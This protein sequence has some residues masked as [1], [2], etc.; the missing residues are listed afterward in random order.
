MKC[1]I[2]GDLDPRLIILLPLHQS[3]GKLDT[4]ACEA[5]ATK[6]TV[7]CV[8]H[9]RPHQGFRDGTTAC[10][11]CVEELVKENISRVF[12]I[13][14]EVLENLSDEERNRLTDAIDIPSEIMNCSSWDTILRFVACKA[15]RMHYN[16]DEIVALIREEKSVDVILW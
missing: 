9:N 6:S 2:C 4:M 7:Y 8:K 12:D 10:L 13:Q 1:E 5:C 15:L 14:S 16:I 11:H 3:D